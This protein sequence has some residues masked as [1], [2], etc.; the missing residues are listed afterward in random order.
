MTIRYGTLYK[1][2]PV[3]DFHKNNPNKKFNIIT[4]LPHVIDES[5]ES[6]IELYLNHKAI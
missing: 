4:K 2:A 3:G 5:I 6:K 1:R